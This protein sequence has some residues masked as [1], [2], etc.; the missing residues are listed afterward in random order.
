MT[1][2]AWVNSVHPASWWLLGLAGGAAATLASTG[3]YSGLLCALSVVMVAI[4]R[5]R[6]RQQ[7]SLRF[8]LGMSAFVI[9]LRVAFRL[10]FGDQPVG[11]TDLGVAL[12]DGLKIAAIILC[13]AVANTLADPRKLLRSTPPALY[14]VATAIAISLNFAP[15]LIASLARVRRAARLR[16]RSKGLGAFKSIIVP[17]LTDALERSL[18][19]AASMDARGFGVQSPRPRASRR[20]SLG[21]A[22]VALASVST[23]LFLLLTTN[24]GLAATAAATAGVMALVAY[25]RVSGRGSTR[26]RLVRQKLAAIDAVLWVIAVGVVAFGWWVSVG[27][28]TV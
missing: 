15:Q 10:V 26:T 8:Y 13:V 23:A 2:P 22:G 18:Q 12:G 19:L 16:G 27:P 20:L 7:K 14:Q 3:W 9:G 11:L 28:V 17:A 5:D 4:L 25:L 24:E 1:Q 6:T 21:L